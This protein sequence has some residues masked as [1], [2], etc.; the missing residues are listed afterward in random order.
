[1]SN[2]TFQPFSIDV[3]FDDNSY[4]VAEHVL[5]H[6]DDRGVSEVLEPQKGH[7]ATTLHKIVNA[8]VTSS[9]RERFA[10]MLKFESGHRI[11][12]KSIPGTV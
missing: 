4:L 2:V 11:K 6:V 12:I 3:A 1:V 7:G 5:E 10:W 8:L 9:E